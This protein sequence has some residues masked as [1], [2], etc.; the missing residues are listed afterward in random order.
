MCHLSRSRSTTLLKRMSLSRLWSQCRQGKTHKKLNQCR[1]TTTT[2]SE[3]KK[4][5][6]RKKKRATRLK[7]NMMKTT[8]LGAMP[9]RMRCSMMPMRSK[10][11]KMKPQSPLP[12]RDLLNCIN[13]TTPPEFRIKRIQRPGREEY[14]AIVEILSRPNVPSRHKDQHSGP[15]T[16]MQ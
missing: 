8:F 14:K 16:R 5:M 11:L 2:T 9:R 6:R 3:S 4:T 10:L 1:R 12:L 13:I 15:L 7:V